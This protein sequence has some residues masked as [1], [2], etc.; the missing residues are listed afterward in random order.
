MLHALLPV[1]SVGAGLDL[2]PISLSLHASQVD[3]HPPG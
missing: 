1:L 3:S 2:N